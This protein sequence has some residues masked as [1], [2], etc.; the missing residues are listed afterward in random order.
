MLQRR[1]DIGRLLLN[2]SF[3]P[4]RGL[5]PLLFIFA[6]PFIAWWRERVARWS[7]LES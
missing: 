1:L 6:Q 5:R 4:W 7:R 3:G 2:L